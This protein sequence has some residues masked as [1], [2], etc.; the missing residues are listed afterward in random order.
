MRITNYRHGLFAAAA[1][2]VLALAAC[3]K[4]AQNAP[5]AS[6]TVAATP[7]PGALPPTDANGV[8]LAATPAALPQAPPAPLAYATAPRVRY[9]YIDRARALNGAFVDSPPDYAVDY[10][11]GQ[12]W[13]WRARDG[14]VRVVEHT[15]GGDR[16]YYYD[17]GSDEP[18]LVRD[19]RYTYGYDQGRL[20]VVYDSSGRILPEAE[21]AAQA[22]YA[23]RYL[24]RARQLAEVRRRDRHQAAAM[25]TGRRV[26]TPSS[27]PNASG[28]RTSNA[29]PSGATWHDQNQAVY[30]QSY[31]QERAMRPPTPLRSRAPR[32][33][34]RG[35]GHRAA[36][37]P[38]SSGTGGRNSP[39]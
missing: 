37:R 25:A 8:P 6:G 12:P 16:Y 3:N 2:S 23:G 21:A 29:T 31:D 5:A 30:A 26:V 33:L 9:R 14:S 1:L 7:P 22:E 36:R 13:Y 4:P 20:A 32:G 34:R 24:Y 27:R 28:S 39:P 10:D 19:P 15:D 38:W 17:P 35:P 18:Y 11:G